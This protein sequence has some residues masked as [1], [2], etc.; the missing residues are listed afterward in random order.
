LNAPI[1][2][3]NGGPIYTASFIGSGQYA[4]EANEFH[5][6]SG[7]A[8]Q[9][10][11]VGDIFKFVVGP[12]LRYSSGN[13]M[14]LSGPVGI[15][16]NMYT[17]KGTWTPTPGQ[18]GRAEMEVTVINSP[19]VPHLHIG[20]PCYAFNPPTNVSAK[21]YK[22]SKP[23]ADPNWSVLVA[24]TQPVNAT[25]P[26]LAGYKL[27]AVMPDTTISSDFE[28]QGESTTANLSGLKPGQYKLLIV[29]YDGQGTIGL[30]SKPILFDVPAPVNSDETSNT[31]GH[32]KRRFP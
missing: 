19:G 13:Y 12:G 10:A 8:H 21:V 28:V 5:D 23:G 25:R 1:L 15:G 20:F 26:R 3:I 30:S 22:D 14:L 16:L 18:S 6:P 9:F 17:G 2:S 27:T 29:A 7:Q 4:V 32:L 11:V 31:P 24:W